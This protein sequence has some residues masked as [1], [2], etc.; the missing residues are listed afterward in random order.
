MVV[1]AG[2]FLNYLGWGAVMPFEVIYLHEG[3]GFSLGVAGLVVGVVTGLA[4]VAA[5]VAG[6][7]IDQAGA[8]M[9]ASCSG[10]A[11]AAGYLGLALAHTP[12]QAFAAAAAAGLGNG[13][14]LPSQSALIVSLSRPEIR[15]RATAV[16]RIG[17][18]LGVALG[19]GLGGLVAARGLDGL[20]ALLVVNAVTYVLYVVILV[21]DRTRGRPTGAAAWRLPRGA[22][23]PALRAPGDHERRDDRRRLGR[24]HLD[25]PARTPAVRSE[26]ART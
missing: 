6:W 23:R 17:A 7:A 12:A 25:R 21:A 18:N 5:P 2:I 8:R 1:Q 14:L 10:A 9:T 20:V 4:V 22:A 3:R 13:G 11:L 15:H 19:A 24:L 16:S 26:Q